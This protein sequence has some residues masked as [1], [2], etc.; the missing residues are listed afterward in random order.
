VVWIVGDLEYLKAKGFKPLGMEPVAVG[1]SSDAHHIVT[2]SESGPRLA[3]NNALE[4]AGAMPADVG[5]WDLHATATPGD[6]A[7]VSNLKSIF[8]GP[9]L[10]TA[11]KGVFGHGMSAG[12]GWELT[13]Q[14]LGFMHGKLFPTPL[15]A[16]E[17]NPEIRDL[18]ATFVFREECAFP[19]K[20]A[21]KLSMGIGGV[22]ACVISRPLAG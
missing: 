14:Y 11:R 8:P 16:E 9:V 7:E 4:A 3:V 15:T 22:N 18:H 19:N 20:L 10:V 21:G 6:F 12:G 1:V 13:A 2:P 5:T 17:L